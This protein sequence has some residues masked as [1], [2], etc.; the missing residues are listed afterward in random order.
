[1]SL[2]ITNKPQQSVGLLRETSSCGRRQRA[3]TVVSNHRSGNTHDR[4]AEVQASS[5]AVFSRRAVLAVPPALLA[6]APALRAGAFTVPPPGLRYHQDKLDGYSFFYPEDW[7]TVTTSG[8]DVFYRNPFNAE[9]NLFVDVSSPSSSKYESV[10]DL[11]TPAEAAA[12]NLDQFLEEFMSTRIGVKREGEVISAVT[13]T[14]TDGQQYLDIQ[15]RVKSYA[16]RNQLA[17]TQ[18]EIDEGIML[19]WDRRYLTV[20]GVANKR[21]YSMRLQTSNKVYE[22]NPERL[23]QVTTSFQCKEV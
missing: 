20:L 22:A 19:E 11:G 6:L 23:L 2:S 21:L 8:N 9:E 1:M 4:S 15:T 16:S 18:T 7:S 17:V 10:A 5:P 12:Q 14:G 3:F 13:R